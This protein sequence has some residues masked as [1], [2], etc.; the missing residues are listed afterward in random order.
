MKSIIKLSVYIFSAIVFFISCQKKFLCPNCDTNK[1][2]IANA[3]ADQIITLPKDS[4]MLDGTTSTDR[5][6]I[7]INYKWIKISGPISSN[8]LKTDSS[9]TLVK[10][11]VMGVY[12]FELTV[13]DNGGLSSK[14]TVQIIVDDPKINQAPIANAGP[15]QTIALPTDSVLLN[16]NLSFDLC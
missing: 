6:G 1:P 3:G 12:K 7:I 11:L 8:I 14:D 16:V 4:V 5:D 13:S 10:A 15:D 9:T 2:P